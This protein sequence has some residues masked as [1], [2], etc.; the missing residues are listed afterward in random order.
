MENKKLFQN[1]AE[2]IEGIFVYGETDGQP[3]ISGSVN[4]ASH[5]RH[6]QLTMRGNN[7]FIWA[8]VDSSKW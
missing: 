4:H 1:R 5:G 3:W 7:N 6:Y 8:E 2:K